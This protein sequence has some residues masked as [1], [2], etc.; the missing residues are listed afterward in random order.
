MRRRTVALFFLVCL[1]TGICI[2]LGSALGNVAGEQGLFAGALIGGVLGVLGSTRMALRNTWL[3]PE[4]F[5]KAALIGTAALLVA[6]WIAV[7]NLEGPV[8]PVLSVGLVGLGVI[9]GRE[10]AARSRPKPAE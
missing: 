7:K 6:A 1:F 8:I 5:G 2:F 4:A 9:A 3:E 10:W